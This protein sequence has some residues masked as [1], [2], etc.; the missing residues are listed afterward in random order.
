MTNIDRIN[1]LTSINQ[2]NKMPIENVKIL[3]LI[4]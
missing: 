3:I 2:N 1:K 4:S